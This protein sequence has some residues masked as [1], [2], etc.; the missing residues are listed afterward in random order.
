MINVGRFQAT[1]K[2]NAI[3]LLILTEACTTCQ[4][5]IGQPSCEAASF[6][7]S[8]SAPRFPK[9]VR[10]LSWG[11][12]EGSMCQRPSSSEPPGLKMILSVMSHEG[13]GFRHT[14]CALP[15]RDWVTANF[16]KVDGR[17]S[18][19]RR[20]PDRWIAKQTPRGFPRSLIATARRKRT[21]RSHT[22]LARLP[23]DCTFEHLSS[24]N[25]VIQKT[26]RRMPFRY[27]MSHEN[28]RAFTVYSWTSQ[29]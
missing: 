10:L 29:T 23:A 24:P 15:G 9:A 27:C 2:S 11:K 8:R 26:R 18:R 14:R 21:L 25:H 13:P 7:G 12:R 1:L 19:R 17:R 20:N 6:H 28:A 5:G 22:F 4:G 16:T 3:Q